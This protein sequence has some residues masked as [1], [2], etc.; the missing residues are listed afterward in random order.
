MC[1]VPIWQLY[2]DAI[3]SVL[4]YLRHNKVLIKVIVGFASVLYALPFIGGFGIG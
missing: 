1:D 3:L 4:Y 2:K